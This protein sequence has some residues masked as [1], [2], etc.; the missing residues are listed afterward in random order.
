MALLVLAWTQVTVWTGYDPI[1]NNEWRGLPT[2]DRATAFYAAFA[3]MAFSFIMF[4]RSRKQID[5]HDLRNLRLVA[6]AL[7][8]ACVGL[9][10]MFGGTNLGSF[11]LKLPQEAELVESF[12]IIAGL[13]RFVLLLRNPVPKRGWRRLL[14]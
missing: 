9:G 12:I 8:Q 5:L 2:D 10:L 6:L 7:L 14:G 4:L 13:T 1:Q 11:G 3:I